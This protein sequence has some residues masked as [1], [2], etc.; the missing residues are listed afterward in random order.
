MYIWRPNNSEIVDY[1]ISDKE[2]NLILYLQNLY[3]KNSLVFRN[4]YGMILVLDYDKEIGFISKIEFI[5]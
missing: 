4:Y 2:E 3:G 1:R 5:K